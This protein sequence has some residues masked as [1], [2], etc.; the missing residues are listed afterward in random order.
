MERSATTFWETIDGASAFDNA[1]SL[2]HGWS[3]IPAWFY[4]AWLV[5]VKPTEPGF[6]KYKMEP[7]TGVVDRAEARIPTPNG[8]LKASWRMEGE[9]V[10]KDVK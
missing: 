1:G 10:V 5:G 4:G 9:K 2:C 3:G 6:K 7:I 8:V